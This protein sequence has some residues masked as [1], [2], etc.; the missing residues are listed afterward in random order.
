LCSDHDVI[1]FAFAEKQMFSEQEIVGVDG[2]L[3]VCF[4]DVVDI[5]AAAFDIFAGL[6]F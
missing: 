3:G 5:D 2:A 4:A 1:P 6:A